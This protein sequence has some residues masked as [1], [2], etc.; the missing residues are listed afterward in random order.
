MEAM[1][2]NFVAYEITK[3]FLNSSPN[4]CYEL[5]KLSEIIEFI[6]QSPAPNDEKQLLAH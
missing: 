6:Y 2:Y 4:C 5:M 3:Y 1:M